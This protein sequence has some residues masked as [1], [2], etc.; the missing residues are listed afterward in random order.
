[1]IFDESLQLSIF[2][3]PKLIFFK[4]LF[5]PIIILDQLFFWIQIFRPKISLEQDF[6]DHNRNL[7]IKTTEHG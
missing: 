4:I 3:E 6:I 2:S 5:G 7:G 1:M